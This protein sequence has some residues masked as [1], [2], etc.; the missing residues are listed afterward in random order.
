MAT[1]AIPE[2]YERATPYLCVKGASDALAFYAKA[3]GAIETMRL[4]EPGGR[5]GH[6]EIRIG[7]APIMISDEYPEEGVRSPVSLGGTP[8]SIHLY[9]ADVDALAERAVA[10]GAKLLRPIADQF[11]GDRS[12]ML[13]DPFGHH[14]F[15][16]TRKEEVSPE[17]MQRRYDALLAQEA[18]K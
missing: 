6:A 1:T 16:A 13:L 4:A 9:V 3:F 2:G 17:E 12:A 10:A 14:W 8:V 5:I 15:F 7:D 18:K 11:Y